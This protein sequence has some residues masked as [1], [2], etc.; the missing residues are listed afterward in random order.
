MDQTRNNVTKYKYDG[1]QRILEEQLRKIKQMESK[2]L[3]QRDNERL[4]FAVQHW[5]VKAKVIYRSACKRGF[6]SGKGAVRVKRCP[7]FLLE[8]KVHRNA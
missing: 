2:I 4:M 1:S 7:Y 3:K 5:M 6:P 8:Y